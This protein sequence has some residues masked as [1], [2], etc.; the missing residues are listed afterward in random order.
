M[1]SKNFLIH[2]HNQVVPGAYQL[3]AFITLGVGP[4]SSQD[5]SGANFSGKSNCTTQ[6]VP[7]SSQA[8]AFQGHLIVLTRTGSLLL[9]WAAYAIPPCP[10][11]PATPIERLRLGHHLGISHGLFGSIPMNSL[12]MSVPFCNGPVLWFKTHRLRLVPGWQMGQYHCWS[13]DTCS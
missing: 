5:H 7:R 9:V 13:L 1:N 10:L 11:L 4:F 8:T 3:N 12:K 2:K 6:N